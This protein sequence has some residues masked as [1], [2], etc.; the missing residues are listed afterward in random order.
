MQHASPPSGLGHQ[1]REVR[2]FLG[3]ICMS[4]SLDTIPFIFD[5]RPVDYFTYL[6]QVIRQGVPHRF[7]PLGISVNRNQ[8]P[9]IAVAMQGKG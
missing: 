8:S 3:Y 1:D 2:R 5:Q 7:S 9:I 6:F 4:P